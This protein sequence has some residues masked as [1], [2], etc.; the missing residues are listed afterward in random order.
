VG[1]YRGGDVIDLRVDAPRVRDAFLR[2]V[3]FFERDQIGVPVATI[4]IYCCPWA[5]WLR[6]AID[7]RER[8]DA[9]V[10]RWLPKY[11][12]R[13]MKW[14]GSDEMGLFCSNAPDFAYRGWRDIDFAHWHDEYKGDSRSV[15][16]LDGH[17][18]HPS[19]ASD[20]YNQPFYNMLVST[21][22]DL[23]GDPTIARI[24]AAEPLRLGV[25]MLDS[26]FVIYWVRTRA[27]R[28]GA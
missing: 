19:T 20:D 11:E 23:E 2:G 27:E 7:T 13:G 24:E 28:E 3:E 22:R 10:K 26:R 9:H 21:V 4:A 5:G 8:S 6:I 18:D 25:Q 12:A 14:P 15:V 1:I 17:I 16:G